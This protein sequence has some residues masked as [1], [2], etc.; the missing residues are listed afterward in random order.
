MLQKSTTLLFLIGFLKIYKWKVSHCTT[1]ALSFPFLTAQLI[2]F[3]H[4]QELVHIWP[5]W[6][7]LIFFSLNITYQIISMHIVISLF[8]IALSINAFSIPYSPFS[9]LIKLTV[10]ILCFS[11]KEGAQIYL[12]VPVFCL[13]VYQFLLLSLIPSFFGLFCCGFLLNTF[14]FFSL[15]I[16]VNILRL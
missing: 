3:V 5:L 9:L 1:P 8:S 12:L 15:F 2:Y 13:T 6:L 7:F 11:L 14:V 10:R 16:N 4:Q